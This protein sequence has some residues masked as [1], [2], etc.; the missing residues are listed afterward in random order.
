ML[1]TYYNIMKASIPSATVALFIK[2]YIS[3]YRAD[4]KFKKMINSLFL[5]VIFASPIALIAIILA[6]IERRM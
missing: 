2:E 5:L 4:N 6:K 3:F 1:N